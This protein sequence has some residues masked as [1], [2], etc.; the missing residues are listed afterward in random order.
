MLYLEVSCKDNPIYL[1]LMILILIGAVITAFCL[2]ISRYDYI[3]I[4]LF[5]IITI[6]I[7]LLK[8][9]YLIYY[10]LIFG[11]IALPSFG[12][13]KGIFAIL[14]GASPDGIRIT[15]LAVFFILYS[16]FV[17]KQILKVPGRQQIF[18][19][20]ITAIYFTITLIWSQS[21]IDS[22]RYLPK[23]LLAVFLSICLL[24]EN[25]I[26]VSTVIEMIQKGFI[27][28]FILSIL[29]EMFFRSIIFPK[30]T[31]DL[32]MMGISGVHHMKYYAAMMSIFFFSR[33]R[34]KGIKK[35]LFLF[36]SAFSL[37]IGTLERG[38]IAGVIL[39]CIVIET[40]LPKKRFSEIGKKVLF[41][42]VLVVTGFYLLFSFE[43]IS[44]RMYS[45]SRYNYSDVLFYLKKG[46]INQ[47][48]RLISFKG[49]FEL[50]KVAS[51][52]KEKNI[53]KGSGFGTSQFNALDKFGVLELH[54]DYLKLYIETG[55]IGLLLYIVLWISIIT[56]A[57]KRRGDKDS[58]QRFLALA[59]LGQAVFLLT[60]SVVGNVL[61]QAAYGMVWCFVGVAILLKEIE[62][63][64]PIEAY[65][66]KKDNKLIKIL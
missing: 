49:R 17:S 64:S 9:Y 66:Q 34:T 32:R 31:G 51:E 3:I 23:F 30:F 43:L 10:Y 20:V 28:F 5:L 65:L 45:S 52:V 38:P 42:S 24:G 2:N 35:D 60:N 61:D 33:W 48:T 62:K 12:K 41:V 6:M 53:L 21:I 7:I 1:I 55:I 14:S 44:R 15:L 40:I 19:L 46:D 29:S 47:I 50:W 39:S 4:S 22:L 13:G 25:R 11:A 37:V 63:S 57:W 36:F 59:I 58:I 56:F 54:N 18:L 16:I 8:P 27:I 26:S